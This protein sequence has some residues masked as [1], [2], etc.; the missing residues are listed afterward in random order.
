M[1]FP[2]SMPLLAGSCE[3][4]QSSGIPRGVISSTRRTT[5]SVYGTGAVLC[6]GGS[7]D[8]AVNG[9]ASLGLLPPKGL[10]LPG[11][12]LLLTAEGPLDGTETL[13]G[14]ALPALID[15]ARSTGAGLTTL[16]ANE[17][18]LAHRVGWAEK[19]FRGEGTDSH[20]S[21]HHSKS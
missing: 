18:R 14:D 11:G 4:F 7:V 2:D 1:V 6:G 17:E 5:N 10:D 8:L 3:I 20:V 21:S 12:S 16:P 19:A 15:L 9:N 13:L